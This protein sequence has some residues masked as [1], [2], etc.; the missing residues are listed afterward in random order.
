MA[1][2]KGRRHLEQKG[3]HNGN[4]ARIHLLQFVEFAWFWQGFKKFV[5]LC[6]NADYLILPTLSGGRDGCGDLPGY[7]HKRTYDKVAEM[8]NYE[9]LVN[10]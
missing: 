4:G 9:V 6:L 3:G 10:K 1:V 8:T 5:Q 2:A 7:G